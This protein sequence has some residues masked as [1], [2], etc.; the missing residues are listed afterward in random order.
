MCFLYLL[1]LNTSINI[2]ITV[3]EKKNHNEKAMFGFEIKIM[4]K[5]CVC[6][7]QMDQ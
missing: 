6:G 5:C 2:L 3:K 7:K 4:D 1:L